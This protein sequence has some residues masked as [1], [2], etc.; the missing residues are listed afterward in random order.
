MTD[1]ARCCLALDRLRAKHARF[2]E[3]TNA[4]LTEVHAENTALRAELERLA[5]D[6]VARGR[7]E[8]SE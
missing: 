4:L 8:H 6:P 7:P 5:S 3:T 1:P 2:A